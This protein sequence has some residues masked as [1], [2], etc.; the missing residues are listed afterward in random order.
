MAQN[1]YEEKRAYSRMQVQT[2]VS[3]N[4]KS[5]PNMTYSGTSQDLS[6]TGLLM[7]SDFAP[8]VGD[9]I[10]IEMVP[11]NEKL[12]PFTAEGTVLRVEPDNGKHQI[13]VKLTS[14]N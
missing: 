12:P 2:L 13:S 5:E 7:N 6:A 10:E 14:T 3:F 9:E 8:Q 4:L 1:D 11:T